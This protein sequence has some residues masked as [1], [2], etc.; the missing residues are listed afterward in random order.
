LGAPLLEV[1][2]L[3][4]SFGGVH[5]VQNV[6]FT[7]RTGEIVGIIGPN[8]AGKT[9]LF[10]MLNGVVA[11]SSGEIRLGGAA[12]AGLRPSQA[13]RLG[14]GRTFQVVRAFPRLS[15]LQNVVVGALARHPADAEAWAVAR[16]AVSEVGLDDHAQAL[17]ASLTNRELRLMELARALAGGPRLLLLDEPL[18]GLGA[19]DTAELIAVVR[20]LPAQGITVAIIEHTMHAMTG[21][22]DRFV[23]LDGGRKLTE[24]PPDAVLRDPAVVEAYL[25]R[26]WANAAD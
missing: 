18:A 8:G 21:L 9:T 15:V 10:N 19:E 20:R 2:G 3:S 26:K 5:A 7:I 16:R 24:G 13:A 4:K 17:G 11:P 12:L 23:V 14:I 6:G 22:V 1:S 25:G